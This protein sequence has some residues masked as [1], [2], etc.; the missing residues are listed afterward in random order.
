M[1]IIL[2]NTIKKAIAEYGETVLSEPRRVSAFL[3]DLA[4]EESKPQKNALIKCLELGYLQ[5]MKTVSESERDKC[6]QRLAE[7]LHEEEGLDHGLCRETIELLTLV[8]FGSASVFAKWRHI[9][10]FEGFGEYENITSAAF[11][12]DSEYI[13]SGSHQSLK[14]WEAES[15]WFVRDFEGHESRIRSVAFSPNGKYIVSASDKSLMQW[16]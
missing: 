10:T 3:A 12:P 6:I 8:L 16:G 1:N 14:L 2:L 5:I 15:G 11:S 9:R 13:V 7:R 4:R